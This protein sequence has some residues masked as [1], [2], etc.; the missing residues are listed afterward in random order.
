MER[1]EALL[2]AVLARRDLNVSSTDRHNRMALHHMVLVYVPLDTFKWV[3]ERG[4]KSVCIRDASGRT[5]LDLAARWRRADIADALISKDPDFDLTS[6]DAEGMTVLQTAASYGASSIVDRLLRVRPD[7]NLSIVTADNRTLLHLTRDAG[8]AERLIQ[9]NDTDVNAKDPRG[10]TPV[11]AFLRKY[12]DVSLKNR[13]RHR[14][15]L[16]AVRLILA[17]PD[18][19]VDPTS[20]PEVL[21]L[22]IRCQD[23]VTFEA[24]F[25]RLNKVVTG[26]ASLMGNALLTTLDTY[27]VGPF[28]RLVK[29][30]E[31]SV[32]ELG[33][34]R[35]HFRMTH[36]LPIL[37]LCLRH[38]DA[39]VN[40]RQ[41]A[42]NRTILHT[43][44]NEA[45]VG[46]LLAYRPHA[47]FNP[48]DMYGHTPLTEAL[49]LVE[50]WRKWVR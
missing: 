13:R 4:P 40:L 35:L 36:K 20:A 42:T 47:D 1:D 2:S 41:P 43:V 25:A 6:L 23:D 44:P 34:E 30:H 31:F 16:K 29:S 8:I 11:E 32:S 49:M 50:P 38:T 48:V 18:F 17:R 27:Q 28:K 3:L 21:N 24:A 9:R 22:A 26:N 37:E 12:V 7:A 15:F 5:P 33:A 14:G 19:A 46:M 45:I 39:D 10:V